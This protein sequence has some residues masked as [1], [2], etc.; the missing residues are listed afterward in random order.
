MPQHALRV[1]QGSMLLHVGSQRPPHHL[2]GD[3]PIWD[4]EFLG[5]GLNPPFEEVFPQ[6]GTA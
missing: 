5:D 4:A 3:K 1:F 6:R 2:K